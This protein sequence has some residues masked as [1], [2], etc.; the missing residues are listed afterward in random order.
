[1]A[2]AYYNENDRYAAE[3]L[4]NLIA[5][6]LIAPGDVDERSI[7][8]VRAD[9]L[10][11]YTQCH[12][13][14]GIGVWSHV[15]RS[16]GWD[17]ERPVW[18]G[19][20]PCQPFSK[21]RKQAEPTRDARHLW[22]NFA[23]LIAKCRPPVVFGEQVVVTDGRAW[24][25]PVR[26]QLEAMGYAVGAADLC[27]ASVGAPHIRQ[28]LYWVA[29]ANYA[30]LEG[31]PRSSGKRPLPPGSC[32]LRGDQPAAHSFWSDADWLLCDD[33]LW[34]PVEPGTFPL[35]P[36]T[37]SRV[38]RVR[39]YGNSIVAPLAQEFVTAHMAVCG[40]LRSATEEQED[41]QQREDDRPS[42]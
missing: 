37:A 1:M 22:P 35:A 10:V 32:G 15:L 30:G 14:A 33:G 6:G 40:L 42:N 26:L 25:S 19:S 21:A 18:T 28:R 2:R 36:R 20:C 34:R 3:W 38:G 23:E 13:F 12:F 9:D 24:F 4:R 7:V 27:A 39:A 5:N 11:G 8:D 17:D 41:Q 29:D 31:Q 16:C